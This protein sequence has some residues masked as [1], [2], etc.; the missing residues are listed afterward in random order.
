MQEDI[1]FIERLAQSKYN[2]TEPSDFVKNILTFLIGKTSPK[3][4]IFGF[5]V[6]DPSNWIYVAVWCAFPPSTYVLYL[7]LIYLVKKFPTKLKDLR[8]WGKFLFGA[9]VSAGL[10]SLVLNRPY[11]FELVNFQTFLIAAILIV[12]V[13]AIQK[14]KSQLAKI[15]DLLPRS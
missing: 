4:T 7:F 14:A 9:L 5:V 11:D 12:G 15:H 10:S 3:K 6:D 8:G 13:F 1:K 2:V